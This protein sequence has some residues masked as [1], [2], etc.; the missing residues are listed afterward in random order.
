MRR[1]GAIVV[2]GMTAALFWG[3]APVGAAATPRLAIGDVAIIEGTGGTRA[4]QLTVTLSDPSSATVSVGYTTGNQ[5][6]L[7]GSDYTA[8]TGT[9]N[10]AA[11]KTSA[12]ISIVLTSDSV[13][14]GTEA[15]SVTLAGPTPGVTLGRSVATVSIL[16]D[17]S[18][19]AR[20]VHVG[21]ASVVEGDS[22]SATVL[23]FPVT[24]N[25]AA[26]LR[27][28]VKYAL[29]AQSASIGSDF[30]PSSGTVTFLPGQSQ[31]YVTVNVARDTVGETSETFGILLSAPSNAGLGRSAGTGT[32][33]N[34]D[35]FSTQTTLET[36]ANPAF[37]GS[38][39]TLSASVSAV[40]GPPTGDVKFYDGTTL[41]TTATLTNGVARFATSGLGQGTHTL[42]AVYGGS[43]THLGSTSA[44]LTQTITLQVVCIP[45]LPCF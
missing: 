31:K 2:A 5:S 17:D 13:V 3:T 34:D 6:A 16:D 12:V 11:G 40:V 22:G 42:L 41:L 26:L 1:V 29:V 43:S 28:T 30:A 9:V 37:V 44:P 23:Q 35:M 24:L 25:R 36:S 45:G 20:N 4:A 14:E 33:L 19:S 27:T 32:I 8:K 15:L 39:V 21:D 10:V 7:A 18:S 38:T